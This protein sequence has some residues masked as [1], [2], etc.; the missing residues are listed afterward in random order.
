[1]T[2]GLAAGVAIIDWDAAELDRRTDALPAFLQQQA[3]ERR[4][5]E[6]RTGFVA[7]RWLLA[8]TFAY[9]PGVNGR[10]PWPFLGN[11]GSQGLNWSV[12]HTGGL[13]ACLWSRQGACGIDIEKT[14][15]PLQALSVARR[16][17]PA[18]E[19]A[20]LEALPALERDAVFLDLWTRK[21]ACLKAMELGIAGHLSDIEFRPDSLRPISLPPVYSG[22]PLQLHTWKSPRWRL[23]AAWHGETGEVRLIQSRL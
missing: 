1:M 22:P 12:S 5:A 11:C 15:R 23:A 8:E 19:L 6:R 21:E 20:W 3:A 7:S 18:S 2:T 16:Y 14:D 10:S 13:V 17:F 9:L 4:S